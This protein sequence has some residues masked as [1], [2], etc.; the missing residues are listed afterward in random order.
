MIINYHS[1]K[2]ENAFQIHDGPIQSI[3]VNEAFCVTGSED[4]LLRVWLLD[5]SEYFIEAPH[6]GTVSAVDI[7]PDGT[8]IVCGTSNGSLGIVDITKEKY[9]TL[10]R[11]HSDEIIAAD[12]NL[13]RN[14]IIT[15]S[16]DTTIRLW[17]V[18]GNFQKIYEFVSPND[19]A[20]AVSS[21]PS[22]PLFGCGF[23]SGTLRI[24]DIDRTKVCEVYSSF[25]LPLCEL[26]YSSDSRL[27]LTASKDGYLAIHNAKL[28]HQPIKMIPV[29]FPPP[30]VSLGFDPTNSVFGAFGDNGNYVRIFDSVNFSLMNTVTIKKDVG[31][32]FVFSPQRFEL[33]VATTSCKI[34]FY[35]LKVKGSSVPLREISNVHRDS[36]NSINFS[37][38][39]QYFLTCGNDKTVKVFDSDADKISPYYFQSFIGHTFAVQKVFFNPNNNKQCISVGGRDGIHLWKFHGDTSINYESPCEELSELKKSTKFRLGYKDPN[40]PQQ[41]PSSQEERHELAEDEKD[42]LEADKENVDYTNKDEL[43]SNQQFKETDSK[44]E[45]NDYKEADLQQE[46]QAVE[47][48]AE[49][50][51]EVEESEQDH[52]E[53]DKE[54]EE[55]QRYTYNGMNAQDNIIW[56]KEK[57]VTIFTSGTEVIVENR[58]DDSQMILEMGHN[59]EVA[60]LSISRDNKLIASCAA[61]VDEQGTAPI[62]I[63]E[64]N[65]GF[66]KKYE[67]RSHQIGVKNLLFSKD[68][69]Y[70]ISQGCNEERSLVIWDVE[71]GLAIKSTVCPVAYNGI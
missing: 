26:V 7:S 45:Y 3:S 40:A 2:L 19:Q 25:N 62:I 5:F 9:V 6:D 23:E 68:G 36:I 69:A 38:N 39:G 17:G 20:I 51:Q 37:L 8:Q 24:F 42:E 31:K 13:N 46:G 60:A 65:R 28:Q 11:S 41:K 32:C 66:Q 64:V 29:D 56:I 57:N 30:H 49:G 61:N 14:Y 67:L 35:D 71:D 63:W 15:V 22:L 10:L 52:R 21:H 50:E 70:L 59:S 16:K 48:E 33:I 18:D 43:E 27:L 4:H 47:H 12:Y 34:R 1:K 54:P 58:E 55:S 44:Q 53:L